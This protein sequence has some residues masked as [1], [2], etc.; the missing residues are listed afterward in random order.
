[1]SDIM[2]AERIVFLKLLPEKVEIAVK[3][4]SVFAQALAGAGIRLQLPCGGAGICGKCKIKFVKGAPQ[5]V[6]I[7]E[8]LLTSQEVQKGVRLACMTRVSADAQVLVPDSLKLESFAA[9]DRPQMKQTE[10]APLVR[11]LHVKLPLDR[12][13]HEKSDADLLKNHLEQKAGL[14]EVTI[15]HAVLSK[16]PSAIR[17]RQGEATVTLFQTQVIDV[18]AGDTQSNNFALALDLGTTTVGLL[19]IDLWTGQTLD[20]AVFPNPQISF[21]ADLISRIGYASQ[22]AEQLSALKQAI[23]EKLTEVIEQLCLQH[24]ISPANI[25]LLM[26]AGNTVMTQIFWGITPRYVGLFPFKPTVSQALLQF[27]FNLFPGRLTLP[28]VFSFPLIGGFVGG[29]ALAGMMAAP[30]RPGREKGPA[31]LIDIGTNCEVI[32]QKGTEALAASAPAGPAL[33]GANISQGMRAVPGALIEIRRDGDRMR[34]QTIENE[35]PAGIC[36]SGLFHIIHYL[37]EEK[38]IT[39][40]GLIDADHPRAFWRQRI[41][42]AENNLAQILLVST[43]EGALQDIFLTQQDVREFQLAI[44]AISSAW[45]LL[46]RQLQVEPAAIERIFV[47]GAF[48]NFIRPESLIHLGAIPAVSGE[49]IKFIGNASLEGLRQTILNGQRFEELKSVSQ[50]VQFVELASDPGFQDVFV[51]HLK[52]KKRTNPFNQ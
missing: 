12:L 19:L 47:A 30:I 10:F 6:I 49:R 22:G 18:E 31:L 35:P 33:E 32:L 37:T 16:I 28:A 2:A 7:E 9:S 21:G 39:E 38:V 23:H 17:Q 45:C 4:N 26:L 8:T 36:G 44:G 1:M 42:L 5:P 46:C 15:D 40:D 48:G 25:Y 24:Q 43:D 34:W 52:L 51:E 50:S 27:F 14:P 13:L 20:Y 11:K 41:Q 29:D 3:K